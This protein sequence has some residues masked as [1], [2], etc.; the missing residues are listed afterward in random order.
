MMIFGILLPASLHFII[1]ISPIFHYHFENCRL[2]YGSQ[3]Y[4]IEY[5]SLSAFEEYIIMPYQQ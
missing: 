5:A 4:D 1:Q 2:I 3:F